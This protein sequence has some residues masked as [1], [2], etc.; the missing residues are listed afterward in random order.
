MK[1]SYNK[2]NAKLLQTLTQ[3]RPSVR[4]LGLTF[5][6]LHGQRLNPKNKRLENSEQSILGH[7]YD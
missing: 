6:N 1:T 5:L 2:T 3:Q 4:P 7:K